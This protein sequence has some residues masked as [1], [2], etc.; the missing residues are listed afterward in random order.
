MGP[1]GYLGVWWG[2]LRQQR[3]RPAA[4]GL[5]GTLVDFV[6]DKIKR[7]TSCFA[8]GMQD[9]CVRFEKGASKLCDLQ[10]KHQFQHQ[11]MQTAGKAV[12]QIAEG[13]CFNFMNALSS[14]VLEATPFLEGVV[15]AAVKR[16]K[17]ISEG[18]RTSPHPK[19]P[20]NPP[21][22]LMFCI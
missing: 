7:N 19:T 9:R 3:R 20:E 5:A 22:I 1:L 4:E 11:A 8:K 21:I 6:R 14:G 12:Q 10:E 15:M 17:A 16:A 13:K 2:G 18:G